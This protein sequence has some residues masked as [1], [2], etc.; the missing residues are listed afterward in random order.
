MVSPVRSP[1]SCAH[2]CQHR[3]LRA[4][5]GHLRRIDQRTGELPLPVVR[6]R[7]FT[8]L[9]MVTIMRHGFRRTHLRPVEL[10]VQR[11]G[12]RQRG[13]F[14]FL[15][16]SIRSAVEFIDDNRWSDIFTPCR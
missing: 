16:W 14:W 7:N 13:E 4:A 8:W 2:G 11:I 1:S 12:Y 15:Q 9:F 3:Q 5:V 6:L 10:F